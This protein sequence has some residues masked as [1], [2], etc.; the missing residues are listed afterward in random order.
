MGS[1][2]SVTTFS[3]QDTKSL[4]YTV[5]SEHSVPN[6]HPEIINKESTDAQLCSTYCRKNV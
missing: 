5:F 2:S 3:E 4:V 1:V 6:I